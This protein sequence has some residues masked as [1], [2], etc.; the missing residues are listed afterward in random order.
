MCHIGDDA[1]GLRPTMMK[2]FNRRGLS[3]EE[4][5]FNYMLSRARRVAENAFGILANRFQVMLSTMQHEI[6]TV[7]LIV[8]TCL[9]LHN[10]MRM[11]YPS[12][13]NQHIDKAEDES[14]DFFP[15]AWREGRN[16]EDTRHCAGSNTANREGKIQRN[17]LKHWVN[18]SA[19][20][21]P[22]QDKMIQKVSFLII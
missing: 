2:P 11:K 16:M 21:I 9:I 18:S 10:L 4:R 1:F 3:K 17:I 6:P 12:L 13:Q 20:A 19:G 7:K 22:W 14:G 8:K 15:G 5:I